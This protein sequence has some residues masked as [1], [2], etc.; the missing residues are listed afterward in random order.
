MSFNLF[1]GRRFRGCH[2]F[3]WLSARTQ[4]S[5]LGFY[6]TRLGR[7]LSRLWGIPYPPTL[8]L[9]RNTELTLEASDTAPTATSRK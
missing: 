9:K 5:K 8:G 1:L 3:F 4:T 6:S 7:S 2:D